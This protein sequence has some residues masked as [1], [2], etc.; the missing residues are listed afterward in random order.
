MA[1]LLPEKC[2]PGQHAHIHRSAGTVHQI[3]ICPWIPP[4]NAALSGNGGSHSHAQHAPED[5]PIPIVQLASGA[6]IILMHMYV[7]EPGNHRLSSGVHHL[8]RRRFLLRYRRHFT[9]LQEQV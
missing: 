3:Q 2:M 4:V 9:A 1:R 7:H 6:Q 5:G 8:V